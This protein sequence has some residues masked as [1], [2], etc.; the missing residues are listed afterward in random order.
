MVALG[1]GWIG[2]LQLEDAYIEDSIYRM[3]KEQGPTV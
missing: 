1:E 3:D 2:S